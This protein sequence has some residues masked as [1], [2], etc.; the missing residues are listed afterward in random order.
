MSNTKILE[1]MRERS[2]NSLLDIGANIGLFSQTVRKYLPHIDIYMLE[3]N[4]FCDN[5]LKSTGI[6]YDITCLSDIEKNVELYVNRNN[7]VCTGASYY[8]ETT[9][10]YDNATLVHVDAK[11]LDQVVFN[12]YQEHKAFDYIKMDTQGSELDIIRGGRKIIDQ[13]KYI[14]IE[15]SLIEYNKG[16]PLKDEVMLFMDSIGFKP[17]LLVEKHYWNQDPN[18]KLIQEDW[19]FTK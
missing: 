14:Q 3:A 11:P 12:R 10:H 13:A 18:D 16:A 8:K 9:Q 17:A 5:F 1:F 7:F 15:T 6:D 4:P 2:V 19:I